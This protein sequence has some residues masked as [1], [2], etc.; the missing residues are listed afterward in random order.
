MPDVRV[1]LWRD[2][3]GVERELVLLGLDEIAGSC[4]VRERNVLDE[5]DGDGREGFMVVARFGDAEDARAFLRDE[6]F[7]QVD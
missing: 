6:G 2:E 1:E 4:L 3:L 5:I 7:E